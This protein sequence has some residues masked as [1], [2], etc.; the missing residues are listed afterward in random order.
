MN[1]TAIEYRKL[2]YMRDRSR[3]LPDLSETAT[4]RFGMRVLN[5]HRRGQKRMSVW[6]KNA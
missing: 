1:K 6:T 5:S 2:R 4:P 3:C